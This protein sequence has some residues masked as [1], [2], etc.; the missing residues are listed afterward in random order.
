M[1]PERHTTLGHSSSFATTLDHS[2]VA[3]SSNATAKNIYAHPQDTGSTDAYFADIAG[4]SRYYPE[5]SGSGSQAPIAGPSSRPYQHNDFDFMSGPR[6]PLGIHEE[7]HEIHGDEG[8]DDAYWDEESED[9]SRFVNFSLLS[10]IAVRLRDKVP[11]GTHVKE[12]IPYPRAFTGKDIVV[13][14]PSPFPSNFGRRRIVYSL[15]SSR[16]FSASYSSIT[17][18]QQATGERLCKSHAACRINCS[19]TKLNGAD[20]RS[21]TVLGT[22]TCF[23]TIRRGRTTLTPREKSCQQ[24]LSPC[25]LNAILQVAVKTRP[26]TL[27][28]VRVECV[29]IWAAFSL[30]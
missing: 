9:D 6:P 18:F 7:G 11:R 27:S 12:S 8:D 25:L 20:E 10:H 26:A 21:R 30:V 16:R 5:A 29:M 17:E 1:F 15:Q 3:G 14:P 23:W 24:V 19:S 4:P 22:S 28:L 13:S 2:H